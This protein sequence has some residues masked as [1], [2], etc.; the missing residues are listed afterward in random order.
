MRTRW[1]AVVIGF[2]V[3]LS[4]AA[5]GSVVPTPAYPGA[6]ASLA[7][8]I[9][10]DGQPV[11]VHRFPTFNQFQW[12]DYGSI[13]MTGKVHVTIT[14]LVNDRNVITCSIRPLAYGIYLVRAAERLC[15]ITAVPGG[16]CRVVIRLCSGLRVFLLPNHRTGLL[17]IARPHQQ[18]RQCV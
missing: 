7:Y 13:T 1:L 9:S 5:F 4:T 17:R 10:V 3:L 15:S 8:K 12:M 11:F 18:L 14:S 6:A 2:A 16:R